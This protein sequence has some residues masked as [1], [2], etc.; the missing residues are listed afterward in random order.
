[1]GAKNNQPKFSSSEM[2]KELHYIQFKLNTY[3][4]QKDEII[5]YLAILGN[6]VA[7]RKFMKSLKTKGIING[8]DDEI[9]LFYELLNW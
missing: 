6:K 4:D 2:N 5:K 8:N 9:N 7:R 3:E 1:M